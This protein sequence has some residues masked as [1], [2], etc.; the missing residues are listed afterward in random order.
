MADA[1][2]T[3]GLAPE[4]LELEITE[5]VPLQEDKATLSMLHDL[6]ALGAR[7]ALDDFGT[8]YSSLSYLRSFPFDTIKIDRSFV[9]DLQTRDKSVAIIRG[10]IGLAANLRMSVTAEGVETE[11]QFEFLAAAGCTEIQGFL[12]SSRCPPRKSPR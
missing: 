12:I 3:S 5:L 2:R 9:S 7:I 8:G 6:H 1:L 10:I 4:R 11:G